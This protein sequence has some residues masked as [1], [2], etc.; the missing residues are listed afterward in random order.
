ME[1]RRKRSSGV[2]CETLAA[3]MFH[4]VL[5]PPDQEAEQM[6]I[7]PPENSLKNRVEVNDASVAEG[8]KM[9]SDRWIDVSWHYMQAINPWRLHP[10]S[11]VCQ[12]YQT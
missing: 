2:D 10:F 1:V 4:T 6:E 8:P 12:A 5:L 3:G 11:T 7:A 9:F